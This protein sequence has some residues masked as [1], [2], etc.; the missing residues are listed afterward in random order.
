[1]LDQV[2]RFIPKFNDD[3]KDNGDDINIEEYEINKGDSVE[4]SDI[5]TKGEGKYLHGI[6]PTK[7][8]IESIV[9]VIKINL[10][11][12]FEEKT[13]ML[14]LQVGVMRYQIWKQPPTQK[15]KKKEIIYI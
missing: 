14:M 4:F 7:E 5:N 15:Q 12:D 10:S 6:I 3:A 8:S 9:K 11:S 1:M 13:Q 2:K